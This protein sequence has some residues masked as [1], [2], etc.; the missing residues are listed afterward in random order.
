M[1]VFSF[2]FLYLHITF[3]LSVFEYFCLFYPNIWIKSIICFKHDTFLSVLSSVMFLVC[4]PLVIFSVSFSWLYA[5]VGVFVT[6][7]QSQ[8]L[9]Y[10]IID[11]VVCLCLLLLTLRC[12]VKCGYNM[13]WPQIQGHRSHEKKWDVSITQMVSL[14]RIRQKE[15]QWGDILKATRIPWDIGWKS[16]DSKTPKLPEKYLNFHT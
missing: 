13:F 16:E 14:A 7:L 11:F 12:Y 5:F 3:L 4:F 2:V 1:N 15:D 10:L 9:S 6:T 8:S